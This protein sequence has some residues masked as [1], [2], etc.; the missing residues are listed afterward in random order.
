VTALTLNM[1]AGMDWLLPYRTQ[2][3]L[4]I[5]LLHHAAAAFE[6]FHLGRQWQTVA[7]LYILIDKRGVIRHRSFRQGSVTIEELAQLVAQLVQE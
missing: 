3:N 1:D 5:P 2:Y 4:H 6:R 7:P